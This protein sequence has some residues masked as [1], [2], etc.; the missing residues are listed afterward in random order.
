[1]EC[2]EFF[3]LSHKQQVSDE[4]SKFLHFRLQRLLHL[5]ADENLLPEELARLDYYE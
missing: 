2:H 5:M 1:M 4:V 3:R